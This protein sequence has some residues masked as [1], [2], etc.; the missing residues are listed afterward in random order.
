MALEWASAT[1]TATVYEDGV[2]GIQGL[3]DEVHADFGLI[4]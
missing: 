4:D 1:A 3:R 2:G